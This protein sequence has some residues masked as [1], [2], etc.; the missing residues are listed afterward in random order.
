MKFGGIE[1]SHVR[2]A[3]AQFRVGWTL[4]ELVAKE[5]IIFVRM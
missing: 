1:D 2:K 4:W 3:H 5:N